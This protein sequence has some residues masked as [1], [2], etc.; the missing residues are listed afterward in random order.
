MRLALVGVGKMG[1]SILE[2]ILRVGVLAKE[3]I[4][5]Y[6]TPPRTAE[7]AQE[8]GVIALRLEDLRQ[9]ERVLIGVQPKDIAALAPQITHPNT[10]YLSIMAGI[11][12][13]V[14]SRGLGTRRVVRAMP[15]LAATIGKSSTAL[16]GPREAEEAGDLE[17]ARAL[18]ATVGDVYDLPE[19]L[20]DAF[21][22]MSASAPAY[23]A[24]VAEALADGGVKQGIP[25]AQALRLAA[26]V[27][28][29]TG[30]LLRKKHPGVL[31]DEVSSPGGTTIYGLAALEARGLRAALVEAVEA[32]TL[33]GHQLGE[34]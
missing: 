11:S 20:F 6:D 26:D 17:F 22:G 13:A 21:T 28:I 18:F 12:T 25:R 14:L 33:R 1:R 19:R 24:V 10:G 5:V 3:E 31:K 7:I 29:A 16:T 23:I 30:E 15:N 27:L 34:E 8:Y 32:A 9:A 4:G 2:G